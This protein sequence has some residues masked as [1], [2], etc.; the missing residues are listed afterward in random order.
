MY[1]KSDYPVQAYGYQYV[2]G[3]LSFVNPDSS[4]ELTVEGTFQ[5]VNWPGSGRGGI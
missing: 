5:E 2:D 4:L 1:L 3:E